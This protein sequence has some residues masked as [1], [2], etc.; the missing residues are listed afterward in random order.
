MCVSNQGCTYAYMQKT[1]GDT[2]KPTRHNPPMTRGILFKTYG[3]LAVTPSHRHGKRGGKIL[4]RMIFENEA[5]P[6]PTHKL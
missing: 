6:P 1:F 3:D 5:T 2:L 4:V